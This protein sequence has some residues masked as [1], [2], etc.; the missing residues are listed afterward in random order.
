MNTKLINKFIWLAVVV[1]AL[2]AVAKYISVS[3]HTRILGQA[4]PLFGIAYRQLL[5]GVAILETSV[6]LIL[7]FNRNN[8]FRLALI[9]WLATN[10]LLYRIGIWWLNPP[11]PCGCLGTITDALGIAPKT[12]DRLMLWVLTILLVGSYSLLLLEWR[13]RK[14]A[15]TVGPLAGGNSPETAA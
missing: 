11:Q 2:T 3:G 6:V 7:V 12:A 15:T 14:A 9:A 5:L 13:K 10:F 1:L 4:D 8:F